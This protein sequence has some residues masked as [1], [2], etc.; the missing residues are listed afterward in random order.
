MCRGRLWHA[1]VV[2]AFD[3]GQYRQVERLAGVLATKVQDVPWQQGEVGL[4]GDVGRGLDQPMDPCGPATRKVVA[5]ARKR[6]WPP[7][8]EYTMVPAGD[9]A[10]VA[11]RSALQ[12]MSDVMRGP[13]SQA[14]IGSKWNDNERHFRLETLWPVTDV[15]SQLGQDTATCRPSATLSFRVTS[16]G[17]RDG[18]R[19][20]WK[21]SVS[22][23]CAGPPDS[24]SRTSIR[25]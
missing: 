11:W 20:L 24:R 17:T 9:R 12:A 23:Y 18:A 13:T 22:R 5:K 8:S 10:S 16:L 3:P 6:N 2:F 19:A 7:R 25:P 15:P 1:A 21:R 14:R 4:H